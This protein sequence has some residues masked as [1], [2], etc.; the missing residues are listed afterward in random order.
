MCSSVRRPQSSPEA[1]WTLSLGRGG[2]VIR[3]MQT[4]QTAFLTKVERHT[5][6]V[7]IPAIDPR[8][9]RRRP[10]TVLADLAMITG[11]PAHLFTGGRWER[12]HFSKDTQLVGWLRLP[13]E[14]AH[15]LVKR[16]GARAIFCSLQDPPG[17]SRAFVPRWIEKTPDEELATYSDR[18]QGMAARKQGILYCKGGAS[19]LGFE[20]TGG[21]PHG[22]D[23]RMPSHCARSWQTEEI[24]E[25]FQSQKWNNV[26]IL[27]RKRDR[28]SFFW[29]IRVTPPAQEQGRKSSAFRPA[30]SPDSPIFVNEAPPKLRQPIERVAVRGPKKAWRSQEVSSTPHAAPRE[31]PAKRFCS[32]P[33]LETQLDDDS[34][35]LSSDIDM[36]AHQEGD[37]GYRCIVQGRQFR[38]TGQAFDA[39]ECTRRCPT[40]S[41]GRTRPVP[42]QRVQQLL[43]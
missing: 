24:T 4:I 14:H 35:S 29:L 2:P 25:F 23:S 43:D 20:K 9:L 3:P 37:C 12:Q 39:S 5:V 40:N 41:S 36:D 1:I 28:K 16:S 34:I 7:V 18:V 10:A 13:Q 21:G 6:R 30:D 8:L 31:R 22:V 33:G 32:G 42:R 15:E 17:K 19:N 38:E 11:L 26:Q 27:S